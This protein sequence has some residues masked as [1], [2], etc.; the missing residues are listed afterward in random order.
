MLLRL[1]TLD[2]QDDR[3]RLQLAKLEEYLQLI[4]IHHSENVK[5]VFGQYLREIQNLADGLKTRN[6]GGEE[7]TKNL[8]NELPQVGRMKDLRKFINETP[9]RSSVGRDNNGG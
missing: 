1:I 4:K 6:N 2:Q 7:K 9:L 3:T 8:S 5:R